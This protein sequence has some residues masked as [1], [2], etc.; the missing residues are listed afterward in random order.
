[1]VDWWRKSGIWQWWQRWCLRHWSGSSK[2]ST[3]WITTK[4]AIWHEKIHCNQH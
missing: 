1:L 4:R 2:R 3:D